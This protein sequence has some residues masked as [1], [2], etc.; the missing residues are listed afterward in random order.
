[1]S[2]V[3]SF[4][5]TCNRLDV[6]RLKL[7]LEEFGRMLRLKW[8]FRDYRYAPNPNPNPFKTKSHFNPRNKDTAIEIYLSSLE[9]KHLKQ[10]FRKTNLETLLRESGM[11]YTILKMINLL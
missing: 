4:T 3:L 5:P 2:K 9:E 7:E 11:P 8:H 6:A 1:M 10:R